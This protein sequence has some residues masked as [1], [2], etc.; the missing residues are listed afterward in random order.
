MPF[1]FFEGA[2]PAS[3]VVKLRDHGWWGQ[4][5]GPHG[6]GK[7]T[8]L[9]TLL[10]AIEAAGRR[11]VLVTLHDGER[12]LPISLNEIVAA[13]TSPLLI[14]DGYEQ[15]SGWSRFRLK[16]F[17]RRHGCGLLV[18]SHASVGLPELFRTAVNLELASAVVAT[19]LD[20]QDHTITHKD[21]DSALSRQSGNLREALFELYNVYERRR[22]EA[23][24]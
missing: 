13:G 17:C 19:L 24:P 2:D 18:S 22:R 16:R 21:I 3:L 5:V 14:V 10:P 1:L 12:H 6:S 8:L 23:G 20:W 15:L 4:I 7:S 11:V 9:A